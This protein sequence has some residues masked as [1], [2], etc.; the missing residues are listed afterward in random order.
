MRVKME[1]HSQ[2]LFAVRLIQ[3]WGSFLY[4][5]HCSKVH[6]T[7]QWNSLSPGSGTCHLPQSW[8]CTW[9]FS[10]SPRRAVRFLIWGAPTEHRGTCRWMDKHL[11]CIK[12]NWVFH[13]TT[14]TNPPGYKSSRQWGSISPAHVTWR[15]E[16]GPDS[17]G[18]VPAHLTDIYVATRPGMRWVNTSVF[19]GGTNLS[20]QCTCLLIEREIETRTACLLISGL[21]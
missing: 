10:C 21:W 11:V 17:V 16:A 18:R 6:L 7:L 19:S 9:V 14:S 20:W 1:N 15:S 4:G 5:L 3:R 8:R 13:S 2:L 12:S